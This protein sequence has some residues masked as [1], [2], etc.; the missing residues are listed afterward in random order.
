MYQVFSHPLGPVPY[1]LAN[2]D[3]T[4]RKNNKS[5]LGREIMKTIPFVTSIPNPSV[6][7]IDGMALVHR[8][9][10]NLSTFGD[11]ALALLR[12]AIRDSGES[13]RVDVVFDVYRQLSIKAGERV[14]RKTQ[15]SLQ[16][17]NIQSGHKVQ[18]WNKFLSSSENKVQFLRFIA[19]EWEEEVYRQRLM[20][21][22]LFL[23]S[24]IVC[25][26]LTTADVVDI[27][28]LQCTHE[29][30]D[31]RIL[32]HVQHAVS[33]GFHNIVVCADDTD[34]LVLLVAHMSTFNADIY[35]RSGTSTKVK[36][37][38]VNKIATRL[39][40]SVCLGLPGLH[41]FTGCDSVSAFAG[42]GKVSPLKLMRIAQRCEPPRSF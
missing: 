26:K 41:A 22:T 7:I 12:M 32:L 30:A 13:I 14:R 28:Q 24:D 9:P 3:G 33:S 16:F 15:T 17:S 36:I 6:Y 11:A 1:E 38:H 2:A 42:K 10:P 4:I 27:G 20:S 5:S 31:T 29:E 40:Q 23:T 21:K 34:V 18:Q 39:G 37:V 25:K 35:M 19:S 8:L